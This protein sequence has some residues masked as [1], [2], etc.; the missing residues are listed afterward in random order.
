MIKKQFLSLK[1]GDILLYESGDNNY[2]TLIEKVISKNENEY[3]F[4]IIKSGKGWCIYKEGRTN[5][6]PFSIPWYYKLTK[7][8]KPQAFREML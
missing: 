5:K 8:T 7:L 4:L 2:S 6:I 1:V 3:N